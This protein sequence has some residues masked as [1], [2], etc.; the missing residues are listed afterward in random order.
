MASTRIVSG[1]FSGFLKV[2]DL[3]H[4]VREA[5]LHMKSVL[6]KG[7]E[8]YQPVEILE[9]RSLLTHKSHVTCLYVDCTGLVSGSRDKMLVW[10]NFLLE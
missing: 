4:I 10:Q 7:T 8:E 6:R 9:H 3:K 2:W 1:D 5:N